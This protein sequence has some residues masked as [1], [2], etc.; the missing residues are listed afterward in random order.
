MGCWNGT[1]GLSGLPI[2]YGDEMYVFPIVDNGGDEYCYT[3]SFYRPVVMPFQ[4]EYDDYGG[5][6]KCSGVGLELNI[7]NVSKKLIEMDVGENASHDIAV[8]REGFDVDTFFETCHENRLKFKNPMAGW[9]PSKPTVAVNF[10]MVRKDVVDR[11]WNEWTFDMY[12][13]RDIAIP[14]GFESDQYNIK[15]VTYAKLAALI[16]SYLEHC[17]SKLS[18]TLDDLCDSIKDGGELTD[19]QKAEQIIVHMLRDTMFFDKHDHF[20]S[21]TFRS[22]F[23]TAF[24][25]IDGLTDTII[26]AYLAGKK[27]VATAL[28]QEC[29]IGIMVNSF[30][31]STRRVWLPP[32]HQGSQSQEFDDYLLMN[33]VT[34]DIIMANKAS[35]DD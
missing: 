35:Y 23:D 11:L 14:E 19:E 28:M 20:L 29:L 1:C 8:K 9:E 12:K 7:N 34:N 10:T 22:V 30:M 13:P 4:A 31:S 3:T 16:P 5:G 2:T 26:D 18:P 25:N 33:N 17:A 32:M 24:L 27:E 21:S 6:E 15:N